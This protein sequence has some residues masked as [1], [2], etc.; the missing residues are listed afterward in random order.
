[1]FN[2]GKVEL[3]ES[4]SWYLPL[5][6]WDRSRPNSTTEKPQR[7]FEV[8]AP[9]NDFRHVV[10][11]ITSPIIVREVI[12]SLRDIVMWSQSSRVEDPTEF[13][14]QPGLL[15]GDQQEIKRK[16]MIAM[17]DAGEPQDAYRLL[18]PI[19]ADST[20][21]IKISTRTLIKLAKYFMNSNFSPRIQKVFHEFGMRFISVAKELHDSETLINCM[22][23]YKPINILNNAANF[24]S[25]RVGNMITVSAWVPFTMRTHLIR[26][27][28]ISM[29]DGLMDLLGSEDCLDEDLRS[30]ISVSVSANVDAWSEIISKR[31]C[32]LAQYGIWA[33]IIDKVSKHMDEVDRRK[34][35]CSSGGCPYVADNE[36]RMIKRDPNPPC[37]L[38][39]IEKGFSFSPAIRAE[40]CE[41]AEKM[42]KSDSR[43]AYW[44]DIIEGIK[45]V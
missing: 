28:L 34:L 29:S 13:N 26:H 35:P 41:A 44:F 23:A 21:L 38:Y 7:I 33:V 17:R 16:K 45:N 32:W 27:R 10:L 15:C 5:K 43:Q 1:M 24:E 6:V 30:S 20:Y 40:Y 18:T 2:D 19:V 37:P 22:R 4:D 31:S 39:I 42:A 25:G 12:A 14:V 36:L 8:D 9:V 11:Q 3:I